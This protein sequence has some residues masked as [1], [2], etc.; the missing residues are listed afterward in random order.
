MILDKASA[1]DIEKTAM[2][3]GMVTLE[4]D[5]VLKAQQGMTSLEEIYRVAKRMEL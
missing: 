2:K 5:G 4:Q 1:L 3:N